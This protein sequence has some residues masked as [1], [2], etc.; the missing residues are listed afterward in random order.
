MLRSLR[1]ILPSVIILSSISMAAHAQSSDLGT[2]NH[3]R[4]LVH[5]V[6][7][8]QDVYSKLGFSFPGPVL[9][10]P[11]GSI[12]QASFFPD[13]TYL[14]LIGVADRQKL[15]EARPWIVEFSEKYEGAHSIGFQINSAK[16]LSNRL[17]TQHIEAPVS[18]LKSNQPGAKP[19]VHVTPKLQHLP[20]GILFFTEYP[21]NTKAKS[22]LS[23]ETKASETLAAAWIVVKDLDKAASDLQ[24]LGFRTVRSFTS[25]IL[26]AKGQEFAAPS[27]SILLLHASGDGP[28]SQFATRR[29]DGVMGVSITVPDLSKTHTLTEGKANQT[30]SIYRGLYGK[31]FV[32]PGELARGLWIEFTEKE[33]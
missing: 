17:R 28:V 15:L 33:P 12:H 4:I 19:F 13:S 16:D 27:G 9:V 18:E 25:D 8:S 14:E 2:I 31:A 21:S 1:L 24:A 6:Q 10:Y 20:E 30:F 7:A 5:D 29:G 11:E 32:V 22:K 23:P 3:V 26:H